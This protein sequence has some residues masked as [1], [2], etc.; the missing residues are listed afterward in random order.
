MDQDDEDLTTLMYD[1]DINVPI[2]FDESEEVLVL[3]FERRIDW[4]RPKSTASS[5]RV[6]SGQDSEAGLLHVAHMG[7]SRRMVQCGT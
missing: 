2:R 4:D 5:V 6:E 3:V 1:Y 7:N